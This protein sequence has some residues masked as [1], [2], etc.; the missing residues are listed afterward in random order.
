ME[1][2]DLDLI[3]AN[4]GPEKEFIG[5]GYFR[6]RDKGNEHY[7]IAYLV[8]ACCGTTNYYPQIAVHVEG[9]K[10]VLDGNHPLAGQALRCNVKVTEVREATEEEIEHEHVHGADG[11]DHDHDDEHGTVH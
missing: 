2:K 4:F 7:E 10:V 5:D 6:I 1:K 3:L 8:S 11:H 9:D